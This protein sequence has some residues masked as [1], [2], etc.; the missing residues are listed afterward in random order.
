MLLFDFIIEWINYGIT[1]RY[2]LFKNSGL[3]GAADAKIFARRIK[4]IWNKVKILK[5]FLPAKLS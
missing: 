1:Q 2:T 3:R 4:E 5:M